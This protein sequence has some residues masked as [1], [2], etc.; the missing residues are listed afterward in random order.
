[1]ST[2]RRWLIAYAVTV[3]VF[4]LVDGLWIALVASGVYRAQLG[5]LL[6][7]PFD[8]VAAIVFYLGYVAGLVHFGVQPLAPDVPLSRRA[9][10]GALF[11]LFTYGTWALTALAVLRGFPAFV[12]VTDI[13]W[14]VA[15]GA[16]VTTV[17]TVLLRRFGVLA[18]DGRR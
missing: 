17:A 16:L 2:V 6:A 7:E 4:T 18:T 9:L 13:A 3:V 15:L 5:P 12:A 14:G 10:A 1:M 8:A 11:G